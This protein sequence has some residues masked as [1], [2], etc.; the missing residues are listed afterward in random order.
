M[1]LEPFLTLRIDASVPVEAGT[2]PYGTRL[3][4]V[5]GGGT[6]EG[7]RLQKAEFCRAAATGFWPMPRGSGP[8][9]SVCCSKLA[10][11]RA[12]YVQYHGVFVM[13]EKM[14]VALAEAV[15]PSTATPI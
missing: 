10:M 3:V 1:K 6:F 5:A 12:F 7:P 11:E 14:S 13:S 2:G 4:S 9:M 15:P 8:W